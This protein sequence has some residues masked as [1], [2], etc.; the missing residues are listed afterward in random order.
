[1]RR[2]DS[3]EKTLMLGK[4]TVEGEGGDRGWDCWIRL[5]DGITDLMDMSL[6][7]LWE[8]VMD[9]E[10][11]CATVH[12]MATGWTRLSDW[13]ELRSHFKIEPKSKLKY[14]YFCLFL[15]FNSLLMIFVCLLE[16]LS[17]R[18][19]AYLWVC[20]HCHP[21]PH[22]LTKLLH[23]VKNNPQLIWKLMTT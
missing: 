6:S 10:A 2:T 19:L 4:M 9:I 1:M 8:L 21:Q 14:L 3:L 17:H 13:T 20:P 15:R 18:V 16:H 7:K 12:G 5:L 23:T 22:L 11:W